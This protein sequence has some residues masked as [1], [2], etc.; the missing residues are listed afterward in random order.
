MELYFRTFSM[1]YW[2]HGDI[3]KNEPLAFLIEDSQIKEQI[4][5]YFMARIVDVKEFLQR[6]PFV[7]TAD[8]F[9]FI[10]E[11]P[12]A[13]WN[14]GVFALTWDEQGQVRVLNE[15]IGKSVRL[16]IQTLTCLMMNYRRASYLAR[17]ERLETDEET[18]KSL[19][20]IIPNMEAY[21][22]DYF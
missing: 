10:I 8:A 7:G 17:I 18:L 20:R 6:F 2:V 4:E 15:P 13:P 21:F 11:D 12:V 22:S 5:P 3:Y 14:N 19:E 9:H 1:I 16:D